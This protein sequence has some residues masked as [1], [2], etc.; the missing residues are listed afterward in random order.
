VTNPSSFLAG[1]DLS[2]LLPHTHCIRIDE[3]SG[4]A[5]KLTLFLKIAKWI[6]ELPP[7]IPP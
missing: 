6:R 3:L 2:P 5:R 1:E 7:I 4:A